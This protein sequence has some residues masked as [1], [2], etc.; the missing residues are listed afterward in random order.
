MKSNQVV[1]TEHAFS[2]FNC[3]GSRD[4]EPFLQFKKR[5]KRPWMEL[6]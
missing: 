4:L 2:K 3:G 1:L 5:E 6:Y